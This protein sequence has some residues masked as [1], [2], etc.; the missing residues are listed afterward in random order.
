[1]CVLATT[2]DAVTWAIALIL[3]RGRRLQFLGRG[4]R[5]APRSLSSPLQRQIERPT[6]RPSFPMAIAPGPWSSSKGGSFVIRPQTAE[7]WWVALPAVVY[8]SAGRGSNE[9]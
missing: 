5:R 7:G 8:I 4:P 9:G 1:V 2:L 6:L 3:V